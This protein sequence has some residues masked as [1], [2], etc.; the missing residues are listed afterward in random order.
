MRSFGLLL[1]AGQSL[2]MGPYGA[3]LWIMLQGRPAFAW[4]L[5]H[6]AVHGRFD[7]GVVVVRPEQEADVLRWLEILQLT[8]WK[9]V[10][11]GR[12]RYLSVQKGL[13]ALRPQ[14]DPLDV[15]LI[16]D[17]A[18]ILVPEAV[19]DRVRQAAAEWGAALPGV[20]V[21][22]TVKRVDETQDGWDVAQTIARTSLRLAQTPQGFHQHVIWEA[23]RRWT[24][25]IPTD[26]AEVVEAMGHR[27]VMVDGDP[28]NRKL[29][30]PE[31]ILWFEWRLS[32][33]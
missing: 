28:N 14:M 31:D 22:D 25:G 8:H 11:G 20:A 9:T 10:T 1:A 7:G 23:H 4:S 15:V 18:R 5:E 6:F 3:K 26:D 12:D 32:H 24:H 29:T 30:T 17:A 19:I 33:G 27:V 16:H 13:E 21:T 2:R